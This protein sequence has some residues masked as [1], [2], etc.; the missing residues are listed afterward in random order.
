MLYLDGVYA[1]D[2]HGKVRFHRVKAPTADELGALVHRI[3]QR[4]VK[5]LERRVLAGKKP[6]RKR[7]APRLSGSN[8]VPWH[9]QAL[10]RYF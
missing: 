2:A 7:N 3:N 8:D 10:F 9:H 4:V 6:Y 1:E 5:F